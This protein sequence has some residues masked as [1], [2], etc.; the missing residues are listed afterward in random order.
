VVLREFRRHKVP[1]R[2]DLEMPT[3]EA[4]RK[5]VQNNEGVAFLPRMVV[6]EEVELGIIKEVEVKELHV[7]RPIRLLY[8]RG[9]TLSHA[10]QAFRQL[11]LGA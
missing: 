1:L 3:L 6:R 9:R 11:V 5:L 10:A 7:E 8:A 2:M 4:I